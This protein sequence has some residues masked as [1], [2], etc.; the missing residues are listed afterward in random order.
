MDE[1]EDLKQDISEVMDLFVSN[2]AEEDDLGDLEG[3][4][5]AMIADGVMNQPEM[6]LPSA[7]T[8]LVAEPEKPAEDDLDAMLAELA[9]LSVCF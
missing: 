9:A 3:E 7:P 5:D 4:L 8:H 6:A 2:D 1:I